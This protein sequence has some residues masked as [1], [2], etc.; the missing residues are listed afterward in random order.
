LAARI[1]HSDLHIAAHGRAQ[2]HTRLT[3]KITN[4]NT[5]PQ[6]TRPE[7]QL[8][9]GEVFTFGCDLREAGLAGGLPT[10]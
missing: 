3:S 7:L 10:G 8:S 6:A 1:W 5:F 4:N 2:P 9:E